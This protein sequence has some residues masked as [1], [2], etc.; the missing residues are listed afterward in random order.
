VV[1]AERARFLELAL[2][3]VLLGNTVDW[4]EWEAAFARALPAGAR[5]DE[6]LAS[7]AVRWLAV[8]RGELGR[9]ER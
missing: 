3:A 8:V 7:A 1:Y 5:G 2:L 6:R 4:L 9:A